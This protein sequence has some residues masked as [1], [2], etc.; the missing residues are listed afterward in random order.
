M[1]SDQNSSFG[2]D[3]NHSI[4]SGSDS[5]LV[6]FYHKLREES[7]TMVFRY[8]KD[9]K[10]NHYSLHLVHTSLVFLPFVIQ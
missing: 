5:I 8:N 9:I 10:V 4:K 6:D 1:I 3:E 2:T 7:M